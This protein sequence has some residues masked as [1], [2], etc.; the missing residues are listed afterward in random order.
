VG[1]SAILRRKALDDVG[2]FAT[3]TATEDIHTS[4]RLHAR[5]WVSIF[6][7]QPLAYGL[8]A[9]SFK[10]F[11]KQRRRWAAGSLG[12]LFRSSDSPLRSRGLTISQRLNYL[13]ACL[14]HLQGVQKVCFL[15]VPIFTIFNNV[16]PV[17]GNL[18]HY[19]LF[20]SVYFIFAITSTWLYS[21]GT[22]HPV[23]TETFALAS[24]FSHLGGL[25]GIFKVQK[26]F[27]VSNKLARHKEGTNLIRIMWLFGL[28]AIAAYARAVLFYVLY[29]RESV[30]VITSLVFL[31]IN[32][33]LL[34]TFLIRLRAYEQSTPA[35]GY[36]KLKP[37][38]MYHYI[39]KQWLLRPWVTQR[40]QQQEPSSL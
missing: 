21:R 11:Y 15:L 30:L 20:F 34:F 24:I 32:T 27:A 8:E 13:S 4:L 9:E 5:G 36:K 31:T 16:S 10:E 39:A 1:T 2:G 40:Q 6:L 26:K 17:S 14:A 33:A 38:A 18:E 28:L 3:G 29:K 37:F 25:W 7:P 35:I 23:Y 22:Y 12:L 19:A